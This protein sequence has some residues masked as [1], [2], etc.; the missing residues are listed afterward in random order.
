[1]AHRKRTS[2]RMLAEEL[3]KRFFDL[4]I[5]TRKE[6]GISQRQLSYQVGM[7]NSQ[8]NEYEQKRVKEVTLSMFFRLAHLRGEYSS[9]LLNRLS[10]EDMPLD[11]KKFS[12]TPCKI[13]NTLQNYLITQD[14]RNRV[15]MEEIIK[16]LIICSDYERHSILEKIIQMRVADP[17]EGP[18]KYTLMKR[19]KNIYKHLYRTIEVPAP[20]P[21]P[22]KLIKKSSDT[23]IPFSEPLTENPLEL[24]KSS[25][26]EGDSKPTLAEH[27]FENNRSTEEEPKIAT[28]T[29]VAAVLDPHFN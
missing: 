12:S 3:T 18:H 14:L 6:L 1:M 2:A 5:I 24:E 21:K 26:Q 19:L 8:V 9:L 10:E 17:A 27:F 25:S 7:A 13:S 22:S 16:E 15:I 28:A 29:K 23:L 20:P 4:L 11:G